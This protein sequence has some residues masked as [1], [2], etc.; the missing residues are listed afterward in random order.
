MKCISR[1]IT[2]L[3][4]LGTLAC[5]AGECVLVDD[6]RIR[7][8]DLATV[9]PPFATLA[10][11]TDL[12][13]A[14]AG[15]LVRVFTRTQLAALLPAAAQ[16]VPDRLCVQRKR[17]AIP[18]PVWQ[19]AIEAAMRKICPTTP[20]KAKVL[21]TPHHKFP[22]GEL[23]FTRSGLVLRRGAVQ[24]WRGALMLSDKSS[25]PVWVRSEIQTQRRATVLKRT[26]TGGTLLAPE[27]YEQAQI[28]A[29]GICQEDPEPAQAEGMVARRTLSEGTEL[30]REDLR[31]APAIH[32][33]QSVEL[34]AAS[35]KARLRIQA[36]AEEDADIG[37]S[38][39]L[40]STW[41]GS[42]L[43]GRVTGT[44]KARVD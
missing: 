11:E 8:A 28:W 25:I 5:A 37:E 39:R 26:V 33:G 1:S 40:K 43:V 19:E 10:P 12:G 6:T 41:N 2:L 29:P 7:A 23:T 18:A 35:G 34:E 24:I 31:R 36:I 21:D 30:R 42:K 38:V 20:W 44:Q 4:S 3:V 9:A 27:D 22:T 17:E 32:R 13:A 14:P 16:D 15:T